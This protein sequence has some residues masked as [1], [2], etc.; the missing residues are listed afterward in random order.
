MANPLTRLNELG[1]SVWYD[2]IRRDLMS[3]GELARMIREDRLAGMTSNPTI[4]AA[5]IGKSALY[6]DDVRRAS[7]E[8]GGKTASPEQIFEKIAVAEIRAACDAS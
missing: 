1:Q 5:A 6:D 7:A 2:Y 8:A 3:S 4:F